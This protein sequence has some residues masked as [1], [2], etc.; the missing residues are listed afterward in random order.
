[1]IKITEKRGK[2][3][4]VIEQVGTIL[5]GKDKDVVNENANVSGQEPQG[6]MSLFAGLVGK[7]YALAELIRDDRVR[8]AHEIGE[9]HIH[10]LDYYASGTTTCLQIPVGDL[11][12]G[13]FSI[14]DSYMR[15]PSNITSAYALLAVI[16]QIHQNMQ[17]GGQAVTALDMDLVPYVKKS[18]EKYVDRYRRLGIEEDRVM[19]LAREDLEEEVMQAS[20]AFIHNM[21]TMTSRGG[22]QTVFSSVNFGLGTSYESRLISKCLMKAMY[23]GLGSGEQ[24]IFPILIFQ[25]KD[26]VNMYPGDPNYDLFEQSLETTAKRFFPNYVFLDA[27]FN[28][29][30]YKADDPKTWAA[31]MGCV[32]GR[33]LVTY[34]VDG[35]LYVESIE[36]MFKRVSE[37]NEIKNRGYSSYVDVNNVTIYD[38]SK[39][40]F[41][42]CLKV[43]ENPNK[44]D[45]KLVKL[46]NGR[47]LMATADHPLP[48]NRGRLFV[49]DLV[50]GDKIKVSYN[51]YF[52]ETFEYGIK[53][54]WVD[55]LMVCD[56]NY[57]SIIVVTLGMDEEDIADRFISWFEEVYGKKPVKYYRERG[58]RGNYIEIRVLKIDHA[59]F[60][61]LFKGKLKM[62]RSVPGEIFSSSRSDRLSFLAGM[63]DADGH[64]KSRNNNRI[65]V[66]IGSL[67]KELALQQLALAQSLGIKAK[68]YVSNYNSDVSDF[69][70]YVT[71]LMTKELSGYLA[72]GKK[73][74]F[75][76][77]EEVSL[78][79]SSHSKVRDVIDLPL[80]S[81]KSYD[82]ETES[83][84][85][86]VSGINSHNCRT[87]TL[88]DVN[89]DARTMGR[90]NLSFT[91]MNLP[92]LALGSLDYGDFLNKVRENA[93][94][95]CEQLYDRYKYQLSKSP[96]NFSFIYNQETMVGSG[97]SRRTGN[98]E[99]ALK[100]GTLSVGFVGLAEAMVALFGKHHG[101]SEEVLEKAI[102][103]LKL[104]GE[105]TEKY[106]RKYSLNYAVIA[107]PAESMAGKALK[108]TV[109]RYGVIEGVTDREYFT[110]SFHVPVWYEIPY[111][112]KIAI[113]GRFHE[114]CLAGHITYVEVDG[115]PSGNVEAL[116]EI[117]YAMRDA[118]IGYGAINIPVDK[119][120]DCH[121]TGS[122]GESC[123][124]CAGDH[125]KRIRRITGYLV[126]D[127]TR[128][129]GGK[130]AEERDRVKHM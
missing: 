87:R 48:T 44:N 121:Y 19:D 90:G 116:R 83:D 130:E 29:R 77:N 38:S 102:E 54:A 80:M 115:M 46:S 27:S 9:I 1:M 10:D 106:K 71:F 86:D 40:D 105:V 69:R 5:G 37:G 98:L 114:L 55:G 41:V 63:I 33:E 23:N 108:K 120:I 35:K 14:K 32:D 84:K 92:M 59:Y 61:E 96:D 126:G 25:L 88:E 99:Y 45:W 68:S 78:I 128:W 81:S 89:G 12:R 26:G 20:E 52:E 111:R 103:V 57:E 36:K 58:V 113:E 50:K 82:V 107:T 16:F 112:R 43:I 31:S 100:H 17:H 13:G 95:I 75:D 127:M 62:E 118:N 51:Q 65:V 94:M 64:V 6:V 117:V 124:K 123:P 2:V 21:N 74:R 70:H 3:M 79:T 34:K 8:E 42:K 73:N 91:S 18:Y 104:L 110:N 39:G 66:E 7:E 30:H 97:E 15:E 129:N 76:I 11:L 53:K 122:F 28:L 24:P 72:S 109:D 93:E 101:E 119:C 49:E 4:G 67:N 47:N 60:K 22:G 85:F 56:S 125:I